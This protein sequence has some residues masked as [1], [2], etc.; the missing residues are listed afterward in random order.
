[1]R[2]SII[3]SSIIR[4]GLIAGIF[5]FLMVGAAGFVLGA[6]RETFVTPHLGRNVAILFELP[7]MLSLAWMSCRWLVRKLDVPGTTPSRLA[8]G[9][10]AF[11]L[12]QAM[13]YGLG[14]I[15]VPAVVEQGAVLAS[16]WGDVAGFAAQVGFGLTPL[17]A[18]P[19][20]PV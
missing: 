8:M 12:L 6:L 20:R 19:S 7:V 10:T 1:M 11:V 16:R 15:F 4:A 2:A 5:Y 17:F 14:Q 13:E 3:R 9:A 18:P